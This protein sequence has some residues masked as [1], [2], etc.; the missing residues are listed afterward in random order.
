LPTAFPGARQ[1]LGLGLPGQGREGH[2]QVSFPNRPW[3]RQ[4]REP[5]FADRLAALRRAC[6]RQ[7]FL[8]T[9]VWDRRSK[10]I[11]QSLVALCSS[12]A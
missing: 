9:P 4:K 7:T 6:L 3:Y 11:I 2:R 1:C 5:S 8:Q 10:K 12:A